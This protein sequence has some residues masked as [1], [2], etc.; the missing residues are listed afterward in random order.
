MRYA[1][2]RFHVIVLYRFVIPT[3]PDSGPRL[4]ITNVGH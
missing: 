4:N 2:F 1:K 3:D